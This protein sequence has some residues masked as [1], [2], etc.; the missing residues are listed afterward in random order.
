MMPFR[1]LIACC[2]AC[3]P[4]LASAKSA[5]VER[6]WSPPIT[7][8]KA[9]YI[10]S[11]SGNDSGD[12]LSPATA[13]KTLRK[14]RG[15][16]LGPGERLLLKRG[17]VFGSEL[18]VSAKG[19]P[20]N[21][22]E[23]GAY[24]DGMNPQIRRSRHINE[25]CA[26]IANPEYLAL[27]D[28]TVC[29]AGQGIVVTYSR[30]SG[31]HLLI[32]RCVAHHIEGSYIFNSH[33]IPDWW[34][35]KGRGKSCGVFVIG[36]EN[37]HHVIMR[38]CEFF[39]CSSAF[40]VQAVDS[41]ITRIFCHDNYAPNTS[42]HPGFY[43]SRGSLT[44]SVFDA[45]GWQAS[46][47]TMGVMLI[48]NRNSVIR[49]CHFL[50][51]PDSGSHDEGGIDFEKN[52]EDCLV[53]RCT[54]RNNA[55]AAI[56][57][58]GLHSPQ[59]RN[60]HIRGCKFD[61][62]N[63]AR[64]LGPAEIFIYGDASTSRELACSSGIVESNGYVRTP[65]VEFFVNNSC[66][67]NDWRLVGNRAFDFSSELDKAFPYPE[68][69]EID[70]CGEIW[71][72]KPNVAIEAKVRGK[73]AK[74]KWEQTEGLPGVTFVTPG[75][76]ETMAKFPKSG[77][78]R[79]SLTAD[80]GELW[81]RAHTAV[82]VLPKGTRMM[83]SWTFSRNL[84]SEGWSAEETGC[85]YIFHYQKAKDGPGAYVRSYRS[86]PVRTACG[87]YFVVTMKDS[88]NAR[89]VTSEERSVAVS[90]NEK[91]CNVV[92]VKMQNRTNSRRMRLWWQG[93]MKDFVWRQENSCA[94]DVRPMDV[95]DTVYSI[96][97]PAAGAVR[98]LRLD[99]SA[100]GEPTTGTCRIDYIWTGRRTGET[101]CFF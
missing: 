83:R 39:Q 55:G 24:G 66:S 10:D 47:G 78:Y 96:D 19:A 94:F 45:S 77:D 29:N 2:L 3:A 54:F 17:S 100:D 8:T 62:N 70:I 1:N 84:D 91:A 7:P 25:R 5:S 15:T 40:N 36:G 27:R 13:W 18:R 82:H 86:Y 16:V 87:G 33:G 26:S 89:I 73:V 92:C 68:P 12:G 99:F 56:E 80:G 43:V 9:I 76:A 58:L 4:V 37:A 11:R 35:E 30:K 88:A 65:G 38:S 90:F 79:V 22:A 71:T 23:I 61:R 85:E 64:K 49:G 67:S 59:T 98:R 34:N 42:S 97:M 101:D 69:P 60:I 6:D 48:G 41:C 44:D 57:V 95:D 72:D 75:R 93:D 14:A 51:Q 50:N 74:I 53:D 21:W 52:G 63:F 20:G 28:I 81:R 46:A 32:E 31:G